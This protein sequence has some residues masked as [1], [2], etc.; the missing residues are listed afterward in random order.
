M[1]SHAMPCARWRHQWRHKY[2]IIPPEPQSDSCCHAVARG[3]SSK[4]HGRFCSFSAG[5]LIWLSRCHVQN[6]ITVR[7]I[8]EL[9]EG[10]F[11]FLGFHGNAFQFLWILVNH[12]PKDYICAKY[13]VSILNGLAVKMSHVR[14][15]DT[16]GLLIVNNNFNDCSRVHFWPWPFQTSW[17]E[18]CTC[19]L[20]KMIPWTW[21][22]FPSRI[23]CTPN[24]QQLTSL[25]HEKYI[26]LL[27]RQ[28][29]LL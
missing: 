7:S 6:H 29:I 19:P 11:N 8:S 22:D 4:P 9:L 18:T 25:C 14:V 20:L 17:G 21:L 26:G 24:P 10:F 12:L 3:L 5:E 28:C 27:V 1:T 15:T 16:S 13:Q 2:Q 23:L